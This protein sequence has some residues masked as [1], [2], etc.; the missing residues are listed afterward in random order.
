M[1]QAQVGRNPLDAS[2]LRSS[3]SVSFGREL[4]NTI[5]QHGVSNFDEASDVGTIDIVD[6]ISVA[7]VVD[8]FL[9]DIVHDLLEAGVDLIVRPSKSEGVLGLFQ[10]G[11]GDASCIGGF[12]RGEKNPSIEK[13]AHSIGIGW[14]V[15]S[16]GN[17]FEAVGKHQLCVIVED[18]VLGGAR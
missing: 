2:P 3:E 10:T 18:F 17:G 13:T 5:G 8:A 15:G 16:F 7:T 14:H 11:N 9:V 4:D 12:P 1:C 6:P